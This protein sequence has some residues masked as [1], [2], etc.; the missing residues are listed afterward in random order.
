MK[1]SEI[2]KKAVAY[3]ELRGWSVE[4]LG[5]DGK[6]DRMFRKT[7]TINGEPFNF[8]FFIEFKSPGGVLSK[9]QK[10]IIDRLNLHFVCAYVAYSLERAKNIIDEWTEKVIAYTELEKLTPKTEKPNPPYLC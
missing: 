10:I 4:K 7:K 5:K 6:P 2:E 3:A 9:R 1:E 8:C